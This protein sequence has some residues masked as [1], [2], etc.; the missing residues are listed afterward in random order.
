M[1]IMKTDA[2]EIKLQ[3]WE[4]IIGDCA[5]FEAKKDQVAVILRVC[6]QNVR[7]AY[8]RNSKEGIIPKRI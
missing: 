5:T 1:G 6:G 8:E 3:V 4:E 7:I 2:K